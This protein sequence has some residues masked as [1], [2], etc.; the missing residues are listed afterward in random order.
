MF[1][2]HQLKVRA[3]IDISARQTHHGATWLFQAHTYVM[4][5]TAMHCST[6]LP[7]SPPH[8]DPGTFRFALVYCITAVSW[9]F[10][11]CHYCHI[12]LNLA[13][14]PCPPSSPFSRAAQHTSLEM[15]L[16]LNS[17]LL[18]STSK[19]LTGRAEHHILVMTFSSTPE[20]PR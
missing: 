7:P 4:Q 14:S 5:G 12:W 6:T 17:R 2:S 13:I 11:L 8:P 18:L 19:R 3:G 15:H 16:L 9:R 10:L 1:I 20:M